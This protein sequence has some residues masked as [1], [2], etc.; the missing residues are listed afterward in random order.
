VLLSQ[1]VSVTVV[2]ETAGER[3]LRVVV[4]SFGVGDFAYATACRK[5]CL[6]H[7]DVDCQVAVKVPTASECAVCGQTGRML[8][9]RRGG[10]A[11]GWGC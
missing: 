5:I 6:D 10:L 11:V 9:P 3:V 7:L 4:D 2:D 8:E 1:A